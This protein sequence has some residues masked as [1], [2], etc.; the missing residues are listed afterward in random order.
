MRGV[1]VPYRIRTEVPQESDLQA[2][3][4]RYRRNLP[5]TMQR[6]EGRNH[7]S[8]S[9]RRSHPYARK[10]TTIY[11]CS[12]VSRNTQEQKYINDIRQT[13]EPQISLRQ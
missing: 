11:E 13:R 8:G 4:E 1:P 10:Y 12:T 5:K 6:D 9:M 7:R 2:D 3:T